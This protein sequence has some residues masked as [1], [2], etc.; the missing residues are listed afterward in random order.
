MLMKADRAGRLSLPSGII[1]VR[2][3]QLTYQC[4]RSSCLISYTKVLCNQVPLRKI[5]SPGPTAVI[6]E[7]RPK[8]AALLLAALEST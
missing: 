4:L 1:S 8:A 6:L 3:P 7:P 2:L 5:T